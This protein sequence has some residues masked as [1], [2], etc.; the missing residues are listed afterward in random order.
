MRVSGQCRRMRQIAQRRRLQARLEGSSLSQ[1]HADSSQVGQ[2]NV[3]PIDTGTPA[4]QWTHSLKAQIVYVQEI[5]QNG[6]RDQYNHLKPFISSQNT[7]LQV[8]EKGLR[9]YFVPNHQNW[10]ITS[11]HDDAIALDDDDRRFCVLRVQIDE[12]PADGY[13]ARFW[14]FLAGGGTENVYGWLLRRD[15]AGFNPMASSKSVT[16]PH[17]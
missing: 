3:A 9:Q 13:F 6:R 16:P 5:Y 11:N 10:I 15:V 17:P 2:H 14:A 4:N 7:R 12:P 8:N 1:R